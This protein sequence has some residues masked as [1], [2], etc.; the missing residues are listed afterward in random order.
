M[1]KS[2]I[3]RSVALVVTFLIGL[4]I[5]WLALP[6][7]NFQSPGFWGFL[8]GIIAIGVVL[9]LIC[10]F[11]CSDD[12]SVE[13]LGIIIGGIAFVVILL[14]FA[15]GGLTSWQLFSASKYQSII[16]MEEGNFD[17]DI[18]HVQNVN[19]ISIVDFGTAERLGDRT[20]GSIPNA[21]WYEVDNEYDLIKY[22]GEQ[23]RISPLNYGGLFKFNK[24]QYD[25]IPGYVLVNTLTQEA[26][27][28]E[29][30][31]GMKY[32]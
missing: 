6:A 25:G 8:I 14:V 11:I 12:E 26:T 15:I 32:G 19:N 17:E 13:F 30:E 5:N 29:L 27:Y 3:L 18:N 20:I 7:W 28:V 10:D 21:A 22:Q 1:A 9:Q 24:A 4:F 23:Y 2:I 16:T 31:D